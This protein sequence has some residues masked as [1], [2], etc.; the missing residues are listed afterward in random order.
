MTEERFDCP[1]CNT[2]ERVFETK[3]GGVRTW[4]CENC[5]FQTNVGL[6]ENYD[7]EKSFHDSQPELFKDLRFIDVNLY[8]WYPTVLNEDKKAML[9]ADG[10]NKDD[11]GWRV[12][13][14]IPIGKD[15]KAMV[16]QTHKL[17]LANSTIFPPLMFP[18]AVFLYSTFTNKHNESN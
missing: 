8:N 13:E 17:D 16:G 11:W 18:A 5:G 4:I 14:Y 3:I 2:A 1:V 12:A 10:K 15:D 6:V 9:F 7:S